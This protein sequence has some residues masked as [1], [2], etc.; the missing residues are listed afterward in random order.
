MYLL[1]IGLEDLPVKKFVACLLELFA[2]DWW[3]LP[4]H[5]TYL[6]VSIFI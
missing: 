2:G 5:S 4:R 6:V 3:F 1:N